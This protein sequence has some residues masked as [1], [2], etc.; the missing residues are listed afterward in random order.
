MLTRRKASFFLSVLAFATTAAH[1]LAQQALKP[2]AKQH[3]QRAQELFDQGEKERALLE[4]KAAIQLAPDYVEPQRELID[5]QR[6]KAKSLIE[7]Y[8]AATKTTPGNALNHYL[9]GKVY[10]AADKQEKADAE[11]QRAYE[12]D[13]SFP[14][15]MMPLSDTAKRKGDIA[16]A[17]DLLDRA[18]NSAGDSIVLRN[19]IATRFAGSKMY[20]RAIEESERI[21][22]VDP[23]YYDAYL[24]RWSARLNITFGSQDT[25]AEVLREIQDLESKHGKEVKALVAARSG[26]EMLDDKKG[27][28]RAKAEIVAVDPKYFERQDHSFSFGTNSGKMIRFE[29]ADARLLSE[30]WDMKD[31]NQKV[32]ALTKLEKQVTDQDALAYVVYPE[33]L[34][35]Y[36]RVK[37]LDNAEHVLAMMA[38]G[39]GDPNDLAETRITLA[40]AYLESKIKPAAALEHVRKAIEQL[41]KP[42]PKTEGSD[43]EQNEY[44]KEHLTELFADGLA[45][46]GKILLDRG[47]PTEAA[48]A[49]TESVSIKE[50]EDAL[51]ALGLADVS[52][53]KKQ[54]A[55]DALS[56]AYGFEG[57]RQKDARS[58]LAKIYR[59]G[60]GSKKL[61]GL[62]ADAVARHREQEHKAA[63]EKATLELAKTKPEDAP[64]FALATLDGRNVQ[65]ADFRGK[66]VLLSFWATW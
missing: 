11:F 12:L 57:K 20:H 61:A 17:T 37:Q 30:I 3:Y 24:T 36:V 26:Y 65:L 40:R 9:L 59:P 31:D 2:E 21:L 39:N 19:M 55:I 49:L 41:R 14:W 45:M 4:L 43:D 13:P 56:R 8:E 46:E 6:D 64:L 10:S 29:G 15:A 52:S 33:M 47:M 25:R 27:A 16:R 18:S 50:Q 66:V 42:A 1:V 60:P 32:D 35:T 34:R 44:Q 53:G 63:L 38:S 22:K 28:A 51:F 48:A 54:E 5:R 23:S 58:E 62:L 7:Q